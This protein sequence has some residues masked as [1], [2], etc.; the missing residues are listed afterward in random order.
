MWSYSEPSQWLKT[1]TSKS[2]IERSRRHR[3]Q[4]WSAP[5]DDCETTFLELQGNIGVHNGC[6]AALTKFLSSS[7]VA[8]VLRQV[9]L[10]SRSLSSF[11]G[12]LQLLLAPPPR[13][14]GDHEVHGVAWAEKKH[15]QVRRACAW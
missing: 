6:V 3:A 12:S 2:W 14:G 1:R 13:G 7:E 10:V 8:N 9:V 5:D 4:R 11:L 15:L